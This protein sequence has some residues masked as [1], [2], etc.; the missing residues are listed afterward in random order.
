M[1]KKVLAGLIVIFLLAMAVPTIAAVANP[2]LDE[3]KGL[4]QQMAEIQKKMVDVRVKAGIISKEQGDIIKKNIDARLNY[5]EKNPNIAPGPGAGFGG[6]GQ[7]AGAS[8]PNAAGVGGCGFGGGG[9]C[10]GG[11][12][13]SAPSSTN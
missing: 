6:C 10:G 13:P 8:C 5:L 1:K 7:G 3:L 9:F 4:Y 11:F 2:Q 12:S